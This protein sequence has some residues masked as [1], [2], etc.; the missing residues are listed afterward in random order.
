[1]AD[2]VAV[3]SAGRIEQVDTPERLYTQPATPFVHEFLGESVRLP[4]TVRSGQAS[5]A[6]LP[7]APIPT[8]CPPG[9]A[10]ALI[11]P[12]EIGLL[13]EPGPAQIISVH[14]TGPMM[15]V[16]FRLG[17]Q[18]IDALQ[19]LTAWKPVP[20]QA[21]VPDFSRAHIYAVKD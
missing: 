3:L 16:H 1:M 17:G 20:G 2:R 10:F 4:C 14:A 18:D 21:C 8:D 19:P 15:R 6:S 9:P 5:I 12:H 11:R 7:G 13:P